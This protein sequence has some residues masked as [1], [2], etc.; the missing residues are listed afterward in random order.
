MAVGWGM[1]SW[2]TLGGVGWD[3]SV[4]GSFTHTSCYATARSLGL[5]RVRHATLLYVLLDFHAYVMLRYCTFSW[6]SCAFSWAS[7]HTSCYA[8]VSL[9]NATSVAIPLCT[10]PCHNMCSCGAGDQACRIQIL[11][12]SWKNLKRCCEQKTAAKL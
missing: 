5:P 9:L 8:T 6:T 1:Y 2:V 3:N 11:K 4:T 7:T 10:P 12:G